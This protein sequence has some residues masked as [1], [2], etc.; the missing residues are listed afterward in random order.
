MFALRPIPAMSSK[1]IS[2]LLRH[3][4]P[5]SSQRTL[6]CRAR[7]TNRPVLVDSPI[8]ISGN[9]KGIRE[10]EIELIICKGCHGVG[11][12]CVAG[13]RGVGQVEHEQCVIRGV[14]AEEAG[15]AV[16]MEIYH[17]VDVGD[18]RKGD[19]ALRGMKSGVCSR[20]NCC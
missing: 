13:P 14:A 19:V 12:V 1:T 18:C 15:L 3:L 2:A 8:A 17:G 16:E 4:G 20:V 5:R 10:G 6:D 7:K 11:V 9:L